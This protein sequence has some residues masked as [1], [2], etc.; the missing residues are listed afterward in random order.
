MLRNVINALLERR[1]CVLKSLLF[2][3]VYQG[4]RHHLLQNAHLSLCRAFHMRH[5][6]PEAPTSSNDR[7]RLGTNNGLL[8]SCFPNTIQRTQHGLRLSYQLLPLCPQPVISLRFNRVQLQ[9]DLRQNGFAQL[10][11]FKIPRLW[12]RRRI[13]SEGNALW[14]EFGVETRGKGIESFTGRKFCWFC[15]RWL[16]LLRRC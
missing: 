9:D 13:A 4:N 6:V 5:S 1:R 12:V 2:H 16:R 3:D 14:N 10:L 15:R 8:P 7:Y 11:I